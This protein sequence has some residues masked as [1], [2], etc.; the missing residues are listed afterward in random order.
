M[1]KNKCDQEPN[2]LVQNK[3][4]WNK[5]SLEPYVND[6]SVVGRI[7]FENCTFSNIN[8]LWST[9]G[10]CSFKNCRFDDLYSRKITF[11]SCTFEDCGIRN[12][13]MT[14]SDRNYTLFQNCLFVGVD[15]TGSD[16]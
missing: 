14:R 6:W 1:V 2:L 13:S 7:S 4:F 9:F 3:Q 15:L 11:A 8:F 5:T 16:F 12:S 10:S